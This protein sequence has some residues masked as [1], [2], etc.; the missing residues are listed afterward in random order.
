MKTKYVPKEIRD[1]IKLAAS[2]KEEGTNNRA[3]S[4]RLVFL[5]KMTMGKNTAPFF[6]IDAIG[7]FEVDSMFRKSGDIKN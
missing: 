4:V 2:A 1:T 5:R 7:E 6:G 3:C